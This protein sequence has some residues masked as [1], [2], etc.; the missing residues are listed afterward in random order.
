MLRL[1]WSFKGIKGTIASYAL[2]QINSYTIYQKSERY[3][4]D[5]ESLGEKS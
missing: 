5:T 3:F 1:S 4:F 2:S